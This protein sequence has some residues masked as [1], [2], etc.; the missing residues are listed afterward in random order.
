VRRKKKNSRKL[1]VTIRRR[2]RTYGGHALV[3]IAPPARFKASLVTIVARDRYEL[4]RLA[5]ARRC[6][7]FRQEALIHQLYE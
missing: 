4:L 6:E 1:A 3:V 7:K 2:N 5:T